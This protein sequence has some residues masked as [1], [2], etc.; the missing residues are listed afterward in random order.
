[1]KETPSVIERFLVKTN[2]FSSDLTILCESS[3]NSTA[4][5]MVTDAVGKQILVK[6][7][8]IQA[9]ENILPIE[10]SEKGAG[11]YFISIQVKDKVSTLKA[12][13]VE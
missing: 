8:S 2:P 3:E 11:L 1:V 10:M 5:L 7:I 6:N 9:G 12:V 4:R 13:K